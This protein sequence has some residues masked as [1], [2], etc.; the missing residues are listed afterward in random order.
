M[1]LKV[2]RDGGE[3]MRTAGRRVELVDHR[4]VAELLLLDEGL[5]LVRDVLGI[6]RGGEQQLVDRPPID[7]V[8]DAQRDLQEDPLGPGQRAVVDD[9]GCQD[10][11]VG[12][13]DLDVLPV[14]QTGNEE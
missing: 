4:E 13:R 2:R 14:S 8:A 9:M 11:R 1:A 3:S 6:A 7:V 12:H 5:G 10:L